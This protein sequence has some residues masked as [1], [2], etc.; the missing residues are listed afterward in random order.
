VARARKTTAVE[1]APPEVSREGRRAIVFIGGIGTSWVNHSIEEVSLRLAQAFD[2]SAKTRRAS[3]RLAANTREEDFGDKLKTSVCTILRR[4][5]SGERAVVD[6]YRLDSVR[7]LVRSYEARSL[8]FKILIPVLIIATYLPRGVRAL[9]SRRG[10]APRETLQLLYGTW[11]LSLLTFYAGLLVFTAIT[12]FYPGLDDLTRRIP[13]GLTAGLTALGIWKSGAVSALADGAVRHVCLINYLRFGERRDVLRGQ[14]AALLEHIA[15]RDEVEYEFVDVVAYSFGSLVAIDSLF[16]S[17]GPPPETF[18]VVRTLV[19]VGC[20][21]DVVRTYWPDHFSGRKRLDGVPQTWLNVY[22][23][24]DILSSSFQ[25]PRE[26]SAV[27]V[28]GASPPENIVYGDGTSAAKMSFVDFAT[29]VGLRSHAI[30]WGRERETEMTAFS[31]VA[32]RV[33]ADDSILA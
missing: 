21:F 25:G 28:A 30:Y 6:V 24:A 27:T 1:E 32:G 2:L 16:P 17:E 8:L 13:Q 9:F 3:F 12:A 4:D 19:T 29:L 22:S 23:P 11:V 33:Y 18:R 14:L 26:R 5:A 20:P 7:S 10:K 15:E 31:V